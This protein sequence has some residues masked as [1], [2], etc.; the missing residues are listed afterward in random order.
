MVFS[1][2]KWTE[3]GRSLCR[4][5]ADSFGKQDIAEKGEAGRDI[6][7]KG[8][9]WI[10]PRLEAGSNPFVLTGADALTDFCQLP[11]LR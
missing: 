7:W 8:I 1:R 3:D 5:A 2:K 9:V 11:S 4:C 6:V 10:E